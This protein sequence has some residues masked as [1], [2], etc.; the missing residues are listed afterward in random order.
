MTDLQHM[1][2]SQEGL[3]LKPY[4][5]SV[6]KLTIGYGR[7]L[8]DKGISQDEAVMLLNIDLADAIDDVHHVC[9]CYDDLS[10]ARQLVMCSLAFNLGRERLNGFVRFLG[11]VHKSEW[12]EAADELLDSKAATQAPARY[13]Q[14]AQMMRTSVSEFV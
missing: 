1:I 10:R 11:A 6:G 3:R 9:S 13:A 5:D 12:D 2:M 14:L 8:V 7:N 4:V